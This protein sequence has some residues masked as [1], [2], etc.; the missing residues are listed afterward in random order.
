MLF[1]PLAPLG[2]LRGRRLAAVGGRAGRGALCGLLPGFAGRVLGWL[3]SVGEAA[4]QDSL[5]GS[6]SHRRW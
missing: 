5:L 4:F 6:E 2:A 1:F 3:A